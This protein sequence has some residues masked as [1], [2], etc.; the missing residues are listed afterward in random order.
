MGNTEKYGWEV[1]PPPILPTV[2]GCPPSD[3]HL[4]EPL[5]NHIKSQH[6]END[7]AV[8]LTMHMV[9]KYPNRLLLQWHIQAH[10]VLVEMPGSFWRF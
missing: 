4:S 8:Q 6:Y 9:A 3:Y 1:P 5:R 2:Q 7:E 10:E